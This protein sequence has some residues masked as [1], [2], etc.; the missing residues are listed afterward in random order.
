MTQH[1]VQ[2]EIILITGAAGSIGRELTLG[3][4]K[5]NPKQ[6]IL[7]DFAETALHG[8]LLELKQVAPNTA[9][10]YFIDSICNEA[11]VTHLFNEFKVTTLIHA[12]AYKHV[13]MVET[14]VCAAINT[15][16][17]GAKQILDK[18][19]AHQVARFIFVSTDKAVNP[20]SVMG[21]TKK[22]FEMYALSEQKQNQNIEIHILRLCNV[23]GSSG[24]V[25]PLFEERI[26]KNQ[27][28]IIRGKESRRA[29]V[30]PGQLMP[31][32]A[33]L[34]GGAASGVYIP[35]DY[36]LLT[37]P[38]VANRVLESLGINKE[39]YPL[40][41]EPLFSSEKENE[42]LKASTEMESTAYT[43]SLVLVSNTK[44]TLL[45]SALLL[46]CI[47]S[48]QNYRVKEAQSLLERITS[49]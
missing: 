4:A 33:V 31:M 38:E 32:L 49:E 19:I 13:S 7:V 37:V 5:R 36:E 39:D 34:M 9:I 22:L 40:E 10:R 29:F 12:A 8:L 23:Y 45:D 11:F 35:K 16:F 30:Q 21:R 42:E 18:A 44:E 26:A 24:S 25:V 17:T 2:N 15:N 41:Y 27:P 14:N 47:R 28:L 6:L 3:L 1:S 48:A 46:Q 43:G 20:Q